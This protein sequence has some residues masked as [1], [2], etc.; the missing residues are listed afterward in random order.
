MNEM[1][2]GNVIYRKIDFSK[3]DDC[4][5]LQIRRKVI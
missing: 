4:Y 5:L 2:N 1:K 3:T